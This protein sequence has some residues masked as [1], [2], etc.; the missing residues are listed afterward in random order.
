M[1]QKLTAI[2]ENMDKLDF[3]EVMYFCSPKVHSFVKK[4]NRQATDVYLTKDR[5]PRYIKNSYNSV[6]GRQSTL[7]NS[8]ES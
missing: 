1:T 6:R 5:Y 7:E 3:T 2:K 8:Q 4:M